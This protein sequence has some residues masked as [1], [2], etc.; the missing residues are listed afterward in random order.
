MPIVTLLTDFGQTD[1]YVAEMKGA[2]LSRVAD[3]A[4]V[5]ITHEVPP[6]NVRAGQYL[7]ARTWRHFP[8]GTI[9]VAVVDPA[10]G[11]SRRALGAA[12]GGHYFVAP[13]NGLLSFLSTA[14]RYVA[15]P[16]P[17]GAAPTFHG[18]DVFAPA[19]A[20]LAMDV[21]LESLGRSVADPHRAPL[22]EPRTD[23]TTVVGEVVYVDRFGTLVTNIPGGSLRRGADVMVAGRRI[24]PLQRTFADVDRGALVA[25]VGSGGT[26]EIAVREGR[27]ADGL[28]AGAGVEVRAG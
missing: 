25:F 23:G 7:L 16:V 26:L 22:P 1:S 19:A 11:T 27:A 12:D 2:I 6:G 4:V 10:V 28:S 5:D 21:G 18:R 13:D 17:P 3:V 8:R 20:S 15:L 24:G 14:A 9:H